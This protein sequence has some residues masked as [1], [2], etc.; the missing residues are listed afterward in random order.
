MLNIHIA[1]KGCFS[2]IL[3]Y[4]IRGAYHAVDK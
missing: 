2:S 4:N 3:D 1:T